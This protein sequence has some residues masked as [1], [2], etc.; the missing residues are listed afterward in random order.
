MK[1]A[2]LEKKIHRCIF[3]AILSLFCAGNLNA[4]N[5]DTPNLDF[6]F[7]SFANWERYYSY[8]GPADFNDFNSPNI[9]TNS[10]YAPSVTN[11]EVWTRKNGDGDSYLW[12][13]RAYYGKH[14]IHGTFSVTTSQGRDVNMSSCDRALKR[15]P[16]NFNAAGIVGTT[17]TNTE[18][19][20][21]YSSP[22]KWMRRAMAE[23][24]VYRFRVTNKSTLL[25][26]CFA[27]VLFEP[28]T[29]AG[30]HF[31]DEHP[32]MCLNVTADNGTRVLPCGEYCGDA[33]S[34]DNTLVAL[35]KNTD[36]SCYSDAGRNNLTYKPWTTNL[37]DLREFVGSEVVI[38]GYVHD[39]LLELYICNEC[40]TCHPSDNGVTDYGNGR[41]VLNSCDHCGSRNVTVRKR[42]MAGGHTAYGYMTGETTEL[43]IDVENCPDPNDPNDKVK[44]TVPE[45]FGKGNYVWKTSDGVSLID[46]YGMPYDDHYAF[47]K[48]AEIQD[49]DYICSIKGTNPDCP[50]ISISTRIAKDPIVMDFISSNACYNYITFNDKTYITKILQNGTLI[51]PDTIL[52]W[53]W[54]YDDHNGISGNLATYTKEQVDNNEELRNPHGEFIWTDANQGKYDM[55]LTVVTAKGC[56]LSIVKPFKVQPQPE[57]QLA[58]V[59]DI[60]INTTSQLQV[61]NYNDPSNRY[62]WKK[63]NGNCP[64]DR[65]E[66]T[67][68]QDSAGS[69]NSAYLDIEGVLSNAGKYCVEI[70]RNEDLLEGNVVIGSQQCT[71]HKNFEVNINNIP[72]F[73][74][75]NVQKTNGRYQVDICKGQTIDLEIDDSQNTVDVSKYTWSN[76]QN[77]KK[78]TVGPTDTTEYLVTAICGCNVSDSIWVNVKPLPQL[79]IDGPAAICQNT[80]T[81]WTA[82][83]LEGTEENSYIWYRDGSQFSTSKTISLTYS[84]PGY[85]QYT[86]KGTNRLNCTNT[87]QKQLTVRAN[88]NPNVPTPSPVCENKNVIINVYNVDSCQWIKD[89]G[90]V[91]GEMLHVPSQSS[92]N[93]QPKSSVYKLK[94]YVFYTDTFCTKEQNINITV[95]KIPEI[96]ITGPDGICKGKSVTF[97]AQD[98]ADYSHDPAHSSGSPSY[99]WNDVNN[100][101]GTTLTTTP[102]ATSSYTINWN[103]GTCTSS[104]TKTV[105]VYEKPIFGVAPIYP[106][107][108]PNTWDT[109]VAEPNF[110]SYRWFSLRSVGDTIWH[111]PSAGMDPNKLDIRITNDI[112]IYVKVTDANGCEGE[113]KTQVTVKP[114]PTISHIG[115]NEVCEGSQITVAPTGGDAN[116]YSWSYK[117]RNGTETEIPNVTGTLVDYPDCNGC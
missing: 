61:T 3:V 71:Y 22:D 85:Y 94:T 79:S 40:N 31:G 1:Q 41:L 92:I 23:K 84:D 5:E 35:S 18:I 25:K 67:L 10:P 58:G 9:Y 47:V 57:I 46:E 78:I 12:E 39:C 44:I 97:V 110:A 80:T 36:G 82:Q 11:T 90:N 86:L 53:S 54:D 38:E 64:T 56:T 109:I 105:D 75:K 83:G 111:T 66:G 6:S 106:R 49:V 87:T 55:T 15:L 27:S 101:Q 93:E 72:N 16:D 59:T 114:V 32:G 73:K 96:K 99:K 95:Y 29:D 24:L 107:V 17:S 88:P 2:N 13:S 30:A 102:V 14:E 108:C 74:F 100:T 76:T 115:P 48:R 68:V 52:S 77:G 63:C 65:C 28:N 7:G 81:E 19:I 89:G 8:F 33:S 112:D 103:N 91:Y 70:I 45:G 43:R 34:N 21:D 62:V 51:E 26:L 113:S 50:G 69:S 60:C 37:Y 104:A 42:V 4:K 98:T 116:Q 117:Y 20:Y